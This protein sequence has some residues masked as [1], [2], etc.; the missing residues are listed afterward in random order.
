MTTAVATPPSLEDFA[1]QRENTIASLQAMRTGHEETIAKHEAEKTTIRQACE[2]LGFD[3][4]RH[5]AGNGTATVSGDGLESLIE[6][7][8][9]S[10]GT[11][12]F[13]MLELL[14]HAGKNGVETT[15]KQGRSTVLSAANRLIKGGSLKKADFVR[16]EN[17]VYVLAKKR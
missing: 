6:T 3:L 15:S 12:G 17:A 10:C 11:N 14:G 7:Y 1:K 4:D 5:I 13:T 2:E 8:A 16:E 9:K